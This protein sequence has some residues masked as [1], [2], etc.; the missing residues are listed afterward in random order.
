M[1]CSAPQKITFSVYAIIDAMINQ[2]HI[3]EQTKRLS[4][5]FVED[6]A[7]LRIRTA[8]ILEDYFYHVDTA[9]DGIDA[10][11]KFKHYHTQNKAYYDLVISDIQMPRMDGIT[12]SSELYALRENLPIIIL[13]AHNESH[14]LL[15]LINM[16]VAQFITKPIQYQSMLDALYRVCKKIND[17]FLQTLDSSHLLPIAEDVYWDNDK[18]LLFER[19]TAIALTKYEILL[20][21][22]LTKKFEQVCST[23]EILYHFYYNN[24]DVH[25]D[26][27]RGTMMR[28]RKKL[29]DKALSSIYG[30]GYR[31]SSLH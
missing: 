9:E 26:N 31:L 4:L 29:P 19:E 11:E 27:I 28:L 15:S 23:D 22:L 2:Q 3:L 24:I 16:G 13:S 8:E 10:L 7:A 30:M 5:L 18:K 1:G 12:L 21:E 20:M 17:S 25:P 14:Y 6:D